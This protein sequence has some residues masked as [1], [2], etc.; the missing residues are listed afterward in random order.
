MPQ[1]A[2]RYMTQILGPTHTQC[3]IRFGIK[4]FM[5][6]TLCHVQVFTFQHNNFKRLYNLHV[7]WLLQLQQ[8]CNTIIQQNVEI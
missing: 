1:F 2:F 7:K 3:T 5:I 8:T 4:G 6:Q